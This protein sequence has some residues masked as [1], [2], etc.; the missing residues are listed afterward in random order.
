MFDVAIPSLP[1]TFK[2]APKR[3]PFIE[4]IIPRLE[5]LLTQSSDEKEEQ[6][7]GTNALNGFKTE[8]PERKDA[9]NLLKTMSKWIVGNVPRVAYSAPP[10]MFQFLPIVSLLFEDIVRH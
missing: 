2:W 3:K 1:C 7:N 4:K 10:E 9:G 8:S 6:K 5:I